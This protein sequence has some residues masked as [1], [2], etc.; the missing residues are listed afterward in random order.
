[1]SCSKLVTNWFIVK[2]CKK[3][4]KKVQLKLKVMTR[5]IESDVSIIQIKIMLF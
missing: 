2:P 5:V 1:M 4:K 3:K